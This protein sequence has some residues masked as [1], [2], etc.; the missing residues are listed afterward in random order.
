MLF[1][2]FTQ[3]RGDFET[4]GGDQNSVNISGRLRNV[5]D[6]MVCAHCHWGNPSIISPE[7][8]QDILVFSLSQRF[9]SQRFFYL[10]PG[11]SPGGRL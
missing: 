5:N 1:I 4:D 10:P 2:L 8:S 9:L 7:E 11:F 3:F 6:V